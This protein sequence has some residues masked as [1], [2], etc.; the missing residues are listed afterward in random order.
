M[1]ERELVGELQVEIVYTVAHTIRHH[2][3]QQVLYFIINN[4]IEFQRLLENWS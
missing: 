1:A 3:R 4:K 2:A